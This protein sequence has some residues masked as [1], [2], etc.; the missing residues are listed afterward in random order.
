MKKEQIFCGSLFEDNYLMRSLG[1]IV[2]QS[3]VALT[4]ETPL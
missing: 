1:G 4:D 3:D 2:S